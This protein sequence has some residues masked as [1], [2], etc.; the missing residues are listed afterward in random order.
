MCHSMYIF[1]QVNEGIAILAKLMMQGHLN[2][3][4]KCNYNTLIMLI[5]SLTMKQIKLF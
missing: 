2:K 4:L 1:Y 5:I 3:D